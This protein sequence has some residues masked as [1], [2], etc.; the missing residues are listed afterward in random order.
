MG[1]FLM[2][3]L[4]S[5]L[6]PVQITIC[7]Q[8]A[9]R[10][11]TTDITFCCNT[12]FTFSNVKGLI[13]MGTTKNNLPTTKR[14]KMELQLGRNVISQYRHGWTYDLMISKILKNNMLRH[15][16][17]TYTVS[18]Q[19]IL[20]SEDQHCLSG[21][22]NQDQMVQKCCRKCQNYEIKHNIC[23]KNWHS[24]YNHTT[25]QTTSL[26]THVFLQIKNQDLNLIPLFHSI[27]LHYSQ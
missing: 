3:H 9:D 18:V 19:N 5:N 14:L 26:L 20:V 17:S 11:F 22:Q 7:L 15:H 21:Q 12:N 4:V 8:T 24:Q 16:S 1:P 6:F 25:A 10:T 27:Q 2:I 13:K 23:Y